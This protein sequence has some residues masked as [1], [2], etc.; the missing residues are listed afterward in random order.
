MKRNSVYHQNW[1]FSEFHSALNANVFFCRF[2]L[3]LPSVWPN[4]G[5]CCNFSYFT[6]NS[7]VWHSN[8]N[9]NNNKPYNL[10]YLGSIT[11]GSLGGSLCIIGGYD[12]KKELSTSIFDGSLLLLWGE[13]GG[14]ILV[15]CVVEKLKMKKITHLDRYENKTIISQYQSLWYLKVSLIAKNVLCCLLFI[16]KLFTWF[17]FN[18]DLFTKINFSKALKDMISLCNE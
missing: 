2:F 8:N 13:V 4:A 1:W 18:F 16:L 3:M 7:N 5:F 12:Q 10:P 11:S 14:L 6:D 17:H 15:H 9:T